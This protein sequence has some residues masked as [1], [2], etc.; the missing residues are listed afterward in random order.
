MK[1]AGSLHRSSVSNR[2]TAYERHIRSRCNFTSFGTI[3]VQPGLIT[4]GLNIG[5]VQ[6]QVATTATAATG[7]ATAASA[8]TV[9][10]VVVVVGGAASLTTM[11]G[12][13]PVQYGC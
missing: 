3:C 9:V 2:H 5:W 4:S 10:I 1:F 13:C 11:F 6:T 12:K 8:A 7:R